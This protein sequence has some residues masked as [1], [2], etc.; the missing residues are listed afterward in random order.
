MSAR[1]DYIKSMYGGSSVSSSGSTTGTTGGFAGSGITTT[2]GGGSGTNYGSNV[3][4]TSG[5]GTNVSNIQ[6]PIIDP[7]AD[8]DA[9]VYEANQDLFD[10]LKDTY[11]S[12]KDTYASD[13]NF[14]TVDPET[15]Q[16][17]GLLEKL[18]DKYAISDET[19]KFYGVDPANPSYIPQE[20]YQ[21]IAEGSIVTPM[22]AMQSE[23]P[24]IG[25]YTDLEMGQHPLL[26]SLDK[27]YGIMSGSAF[28]G[29][30]AG[31]D[32]GGRIN[33]GGGGD[34]GA[35]IAAGLGRRPKQLGDEEGIPKGLRLLDYMVNVHK[36]NPYTKLAMRKK[37][38]G[39]VSLVGG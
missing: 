9:G 34:Y 6:G 29:A 14:V 30:A 1:D 17:L 24:G 10:T 18:K 11:T 15:V 27:Y 20:L 2:P 33:V 5:I 26:G 31:G 38:G 22:E 8:E 7:K 3:N 12:P 37:N 28:P 19:L 23:E 21:M 39:I 4:T 13:L 36:S 35:G 25:T 16:K 32:G